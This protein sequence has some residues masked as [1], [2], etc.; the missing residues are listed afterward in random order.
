MRK[1][2][3]LIIAHNDFEL[4]EKQLLLIDDLRNDIY[5]HIDTRAK[6][7][8][9]EE[10]CSCVKN[11]KIEIFQQYKVRWGD[12]TQVKCE[13]F[14]LEKA[15]QKQYAYYHILSGVDLPIKTQEE[16]HQFFHTNI[17][18]QFIH[19]D[20]VIVKQ[21]V[22]DRVNYNHYFSKFYKISKYKLINKLFFILDTTGVKLQKILHIK[23]KH[24][25]KIIQKGANWCSITNS[26]AR[27]ILDR[28]EQI[29]QLVKNSKCADEVFI[30]T[31][32]ENSEFKNQLYQRT[33]DNDYIQCARYI[34][35]ESDNAKTPK[36]LT[37]DDFDEIFKSKAMFARKFN[38]KIDSKLIDKI[39]EMIKERKEE[40]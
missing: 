2:A 29:N 4:L 38:S 13:V 12:A 23:K 32:V 7:C 24:A 20:D 17:G 22:L 28:K 35:W 8:K 25:F 36:T 39:S 34:K 33:Y 3:Y 5:V 6:N 31:L 21:E 1:H 11:S 37:I 30:Q 10:L 40:K 16:I 9:I 26:L 19:F 18:K 15:I 14:L 27:Y